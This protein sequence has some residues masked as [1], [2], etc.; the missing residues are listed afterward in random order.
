MWEQECFGRKKRI[1][2]QGLSD[3]VDF[4]QYMKI[5]RFRQLQQLVPKLMEDSEVKDDDDWWRLR[6]GITR[7][8]RIRKKL[9]SSHIAVFDESMSV[10]IP[11]LVT[12]N[13]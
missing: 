1:R 2:R 8:N 4:G 6:G 3:S 10:F 12:N 9:I 13:H 7:F 5:W 11:R